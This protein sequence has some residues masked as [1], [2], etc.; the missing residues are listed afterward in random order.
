M[1]PARSMVRAVY[2][3]NCEHRE[4]QREPPETERG[5]TGSSRS[6]RRRR[7]DNCWEA[8]RKTKR[9]RENVEKEEKTNGHGHVQPPTTVY[10]PRENEKERTIVGGT[11]CVTSDANNGFHRKPGSHLGTFPCKCSSYV[12][13]ID[14]GR[15]EQF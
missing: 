13:H 11:N 3:I 2:S 12:K 7:E 8:E 15:S 5:T 14:C 6:L 9:E 10:R 1:C 4:T